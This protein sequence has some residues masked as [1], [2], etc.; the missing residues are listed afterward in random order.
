MSESK[1]IKYTKE[2]QDYEK[3]LYEDSDGEICEADT[4][5]SLICNSCDICGYFHDPGNEYYVNKNEEL[6]EQ[7]PGDLDENNI[8]FNLFKDGVNIYIESSFYNEFFKSY[9]YS[10]DK[11]DL[12]T[13]ILIT[14]F[15]EDSLYNLDIESYD[16]VTYRI[17]YKDDRINI[18]E[19]CPL[20]Y[21]E[22]PRNKLDN[23]NN[24]YGKPDGKKDTRFFRSY[25]DR[26]FDKYKSISSGKELKK[27]YKQG[28]FK[29]EN[30]MR[31]T[32]V[33]SARK[34]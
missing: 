31:P 18:A 16:V 9:S 1:L 17:F 19:T 28:G 20:E 10:D 5:F 14:F 12:I 8:M 26:V 24:C 2:Y 32:M 22:F 21:K 23:S 27:V 34:Y 7:L 33:K 3:L 30:I 15:V 11:D 4:E 6:L 25:V 29:C 13:Y